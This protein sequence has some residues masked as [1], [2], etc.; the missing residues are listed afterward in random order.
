M[1][2][3]Y[4]T[5]ITAYVPYPKSEEIRT[6]AGSIGTAVAKAV[7]EYKKLN[8]GQRIKELIIKITQL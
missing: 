8:K 7:K 3:N 6:T 4:W 2:K 5:K 1:K